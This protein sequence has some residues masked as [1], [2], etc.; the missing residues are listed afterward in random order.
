VIQLEPPKEIEAYIHRSGRTA[1]AGKLGTCITLY[2]NKQAQL[3]EKIEDT[4]GIKFKKVG[5]PQP[6][7]IVKESW[8]DVSKQFDKIDK[9]VLPMF[10]EAAQVRLC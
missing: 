9:E 1:R 4:A 8:R 10:E 2:T 7:D 6:S 3:L 5:P